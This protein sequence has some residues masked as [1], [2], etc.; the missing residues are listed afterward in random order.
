L[1]PPNVHEYQD[2]DRN[3]NEQLVKLQTECI[4][5]YLLHGINRAWW[6]RIRDL[7]V[8]EWAEKAMADGRIGHLGFSFH[9]EFS[10]FQEIVDAY[11]RWALCMIQY[12]YM[13]IRGEAG[14]RGIQYAASKGLAVVIMEPLLGG[15]LAHPPQTIQELWDSSVI[16]RKLADWGLQWLWNQPEVAVVLSGMNAMQQ[17]KENI[18]SAEASGIG[19]LTEEELTLVD[20]VR[21]KYQ[22]FA[23]I[24]CTMCGYCLPCPHSIDIPYNF[25]VYNDGLMYEKE[26][27]GN[28]RFWYWFM[29]ESKG[30][31]GD[32]HQ[33]GRADRC[34]QC[35]ECEKK[36]PQGIPI[37]T[38]LPIVHKV[39][40]EGKPY[41]E[42]LHRSAT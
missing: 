17:V 33:R 37:S 29:S 8:F 20:R 40:G 11:D 15:K 25:K 26:H 24:P 4:D 28:A 27:P 38:W 1:F 16:K 7:G 39:I 9:D 10:C 35:Q 21:A 12:N 36:C 42:C 32:Y 13:G 19:L 34:A 6:P 5:F 18:A 2:F 31:E 41:D 30:F 14:M 3:L 22:E 23:T